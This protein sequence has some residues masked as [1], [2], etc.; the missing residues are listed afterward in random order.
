MYV[1]LE[2]STTIESLFLEESQQDARSST[3]ERYIVT[4]SE[5]TWKLE[6][7]DLSNRTT[8]SGV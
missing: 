5:E 2:V 3:F 1:A 7:L 4:E 8:S 6:R